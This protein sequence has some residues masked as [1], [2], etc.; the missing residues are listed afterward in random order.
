M[1]TPPPVDI[2]TFSRIPPSQKEIYEAA[3]AAAKA[4]KRKAYEVNDN[5]DENL[6]KVRRMLPLASGLNRVPITEYSGLEKSNR[7]A[8]ALKGRNDIR[9]AQNANGENVSIPFL[10]F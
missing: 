1:A 2:P 3:K 5:N 6:S 7:N 8:S 10:G 4:A 9:D